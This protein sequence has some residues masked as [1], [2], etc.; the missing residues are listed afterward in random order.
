M[1]SFSPELNRLTISIPQVGHQNLFDQKLK[2]E[3]NLTI[4]YVTPRALLTGEGYNNLYNHFYSKI[5]ETQGNPGLL[6]LYT[7]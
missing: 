5:F 3:E 4:E 1:S 7:I 2:G 6:T